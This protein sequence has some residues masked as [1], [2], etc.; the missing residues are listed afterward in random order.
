[1]NR[2]NTEDF[3]AGVHHEQNQQPDDFVIKQ[4]DTPRLYWS[5][6]LGWVQLSDAD[7]FTREEKNSLS[8]PMGGYWVAI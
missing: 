1:M 4:H 6:D 2:R 3:M 5:N 7:T 8:L